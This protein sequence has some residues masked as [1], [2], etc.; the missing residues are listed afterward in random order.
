MVPFPESSLRRPRRRVEPVPDGR[1][2]HSQNIPENL[3]SEM[4]K[5][6][7]A[8]AGLALAS[9]AASAQ[10]EAVTA[11]LSAGAG[12]LADSVELGADALVG[13]NS[14]DNGGNLNNVAG[15]GLLG[16]ADL[17][18]DVLTGAAGEANDGA[19][20]GGDLL[21]NSAM[22]GLDALATGINGGSQVLGDGIN[23]GATALAEA[24]RMGDLEG[25]NTGSG[26]NP[27]SLG[28]DGL[29]APLT[30]LSSASPL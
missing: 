11:P 4:R 30:G 17:L 1:D 16:G 18:S 7:I 27:A 19:T 28:L 15:S 8:A 10:T 21:G 9:G 25:G 23:G 2:D 13:V 12:L 6:L 29:L 26:F 3:E 5:Q 22:A 20:E 14:A 24:I